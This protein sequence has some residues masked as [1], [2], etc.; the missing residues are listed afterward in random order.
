M[1]KIRRHYPM[2]IGYKNVALYNAGPIGLESKTFV[3]EYQLCDLLNIYTA[4]D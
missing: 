2:S 1:K 3:K 4:P